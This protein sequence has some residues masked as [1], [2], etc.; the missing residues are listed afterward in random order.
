MFFLSELSGRA[1][2]FGEAIH[3]TGAEGFLH[4]MCRNSVEGIQAG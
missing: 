4:L 3:K 1:T 2:L